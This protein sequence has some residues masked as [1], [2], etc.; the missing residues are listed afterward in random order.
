MKIEVTEHGRRIEIEVTEEGVH[1]RIHPAPSV[2]TVP[3]DHAVVMRGGGGAGGAGGSV[4]IHG[5][6]GRT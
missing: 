1:L 6:G 4:T 3:R 5:P 2:M